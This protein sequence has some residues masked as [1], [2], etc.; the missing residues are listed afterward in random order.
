MGGRDRS[1]A[2]RST[3]PES[4]W[5]RGAGAL[6][7]ASLAIGLA[8]WAVPASATA[9]APHAASPFT[10]VWTGA[11]TLSPP[12]PCAKLKPACPDPLQVQV[13]IPAITATGTG[14]ITFPGWQCAGP[15]A[16]TATGASLS[17]ADATLT[18]TSGFDCTLLEG[19]GTM[20]APV[21]GQSN[22]KQIVGQSDGLNEKLTGTL[23]GFT[24]QSQ[25]GGTGSCDVTAPSPQIICLSVA[26]CPQGGTL[27]STVTVGAFSNGHLAPNTPVTI[28]FL[29]PTKAHDTSGS[30]C[31]ASNGHT[32]TGRTNSLGLFTFTYRAAG[33]NTPPIASFCMVR[34]TVGHATIISAI[35]QT[36]DPAPWTVHGS[37]T[38]VTRFNIPS[39]KAHLH[40]YVR[41]PNGTPSYVNNDPTTIYSEIPSTVGACGALSPLVKK[42]GHPNG[43]ATITYS[44]S[45]VGGTSSH[46]VFCTLVGQEADTGATSNDVVVYQRKG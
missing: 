27:V 45:T 42:T 7:A 20:G 24:P 25:C 37:P 46:K 32:K 43:R 11:L 10:G 6:G 9:V 21:S 39:N 18:G 26:S 15:L 5:R 17:V 19:K 22:W 8:V 36:N 4:R 44:P 35:D 23:T 1:S 41:N 38:P 12:P 30:W 16:L 34:A 40:L 29:S 28:R 14:T 3:R 31:Q 33:S 2:T 13:Q